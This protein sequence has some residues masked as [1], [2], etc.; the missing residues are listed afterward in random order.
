MKLP[1]QI[2]PPPIGPNDI[3]SRDYANAAGGGAWTYIRSVEVTGSAVQDIDLT[4]LDGDSDERYLLLFDLLWG[5]APSAV[6]YWCYPN[7]SAISSGMTERLYSSNAANG[8][9][10]NVNEWRFAY[11]YSRVLGN[12][13]IAASSGDRRMWHSRTAVPTSTA[14]DATTNHYAG[15]WNDTS[16]NITSLKLHASNASGF[17]VG[18][19]V[20]IYKLHKGAT[21]VT[22]QG[23]YIEAE[24]SSDQGSV[25]ADN[26]TIL[27][28]NAVRSRG[29]LSVNAS[30]KFSA[31]KAGRT[32]FLLANLQMSGTSS[33]RLPFNWYDLTN[34]TDIGGVGTAV[35]AG[36]GGTTAYT[37]VATAVITPTMDIEVELRTSAVPTAGTCTISSGVDSWSEHASTALIMEIGATTNIVG[38]TVLSADSDTISVTGLNGDAHGEYIIDFHILVAGSGSAFTATAHPNGETA[39]L[40]SRYSAN[41]NATP[42]ARTDWIVFAASSQSSREAIGR[43]RLSANRTQNGVSH[44][45]SMMSEAI[46]HYAANP[47][48]SFYTVGGYWNDAAANLTSFDIVTTL[49]SGFLA[50][51]RVTVRKV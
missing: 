15:F 43:M 35:S 21:G 4:G 20:H 48:A 25:T 46:L 31:L 12:M 38:E 24:L 45:R 37:N 11:N 6:E 39:N 33:T 44:R 19:K 42:D 27:F 3:A 10:E 5:G 9:A 18:S 34:S 17:A 32:Y 47:Y 14:S 2:V 23:A 16:A 28:D 49:A 40:F 8:S 30:G 41:F 1:S 51:S 26:T 7:G 13:E 50:G 29:D 22:A 36:F